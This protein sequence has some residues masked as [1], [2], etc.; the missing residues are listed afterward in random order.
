VRYNFRHLVQTTDST[1][2]A[3]TYYS[4]MLLLTCSSGPRLCPKTNWL[5]TTRTLAR[6]WE[7]SVC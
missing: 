3:D 5:P 6:K 7:H 1:V 2:G 4:L